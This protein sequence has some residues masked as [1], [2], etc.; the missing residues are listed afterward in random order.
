MIA[1]LL[2]CLYYL[3]FRRR[4]VKELS[5]IPSPLPLVD[6]VAASGI[7]VTSTSQGM[8][9][10]ILNEPGKETKI[11]TYTEQGSGPIGVGDF[12]INMPAMGN[13]H[14]APALTNG[15]LAN[16][17][18]DPSELRLLQHEHH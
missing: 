13:G 5:G 11:T 7:P 1:F 2:T 17:N 10:T 15:L 4:Y 3:A 9:T 18:T 14:A 12:A 16:G 8:S 6:K